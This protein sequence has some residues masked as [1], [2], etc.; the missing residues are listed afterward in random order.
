MQISGFDLCVSLR[1]LAAVGLEVLL[2]ISESLGQFLEGCTVL[3][4]V[5]DH[6]LEYQNCGK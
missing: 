2:V 4:Q 3:P 5:K 6:L 1:V